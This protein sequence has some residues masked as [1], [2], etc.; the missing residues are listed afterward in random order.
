MP[1]SPA[2]LKKRQFKKIKTSTSPSKST[3]IPS[4][5]SLNATAQEKVEAWFR[6]ESTQAGYKRSVK[7]AKAFAERQAGEMEAAELAG[8]VREYDP[9]EWATAF[10]V[11]GE[12]TP[13]VLHAFVVYKC[14]VLEN[15]YKTAE[16]IRSAF[17]HYFT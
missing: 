7:E 6:A 11:I 16:A 10:D 14:E 1:P 3:H 4:I 8:G 15:S 12:V 5:A 13:K 17:K 9:G 2:S